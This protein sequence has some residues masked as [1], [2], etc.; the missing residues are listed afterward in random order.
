M[1]KKEDKKFTRF[2]SIDFLRAIAIILMVLVHFAK[3]LTMPAGKQ[4]SFY[5]FINYLGFMAAPLFLFIVGISLIFSINKQREK[6]NKHILLR[7]L[8]FIVFGFLFMIAWNADILHFIGLFILISFFSLKLNK[9]YRIILANVFL[10]LAP[11]LLLFIN[12][13]ESWARLS[14]EFAGFFTVSGFFKNMLLTGFHPI[15]PWLFLVLMGTVIG[16]FFLNNKKPKDFLFYNLFIGI[17]LIF[18]GFFLHFIGIWKIH[19]YPSTPSYMILSLGICLFLLGL[20]FWLFEIKKLGK[21]ICKPLFFL[22]TVSFSMY[23]FHIV[24]GI[25]IF[26]FLDSLFSLSLLFV[27]IYTLSF[28]IGFSLLLY[29]WVKKL[30]FGPFELLVRIFS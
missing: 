27:V 11:V 5:P 19:F 28:L 9:T 7:S 8:F 3:F 21:T 18:F 23:I 2:V 25:G 14:Y 20:F 13:N 6:P 24:L 12:Y 15:F 26:Y 16:E 4:S 1:V 17:V 22:G 10:W 30:K 29:L